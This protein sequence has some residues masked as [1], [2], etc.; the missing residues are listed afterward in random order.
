MTPQPL[1]L[2]RIVSQQD[3][4]PQH[5]AGQPWIRPYTKLGSLLLKEQC[6]EFFKPHFSFAKLTYSVMIDMLNYCLYITKK[7][8]SKLENSDSRNQTDF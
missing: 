6:H 3:V 8:L 5:L 4:H 2:L 1:P 7:F